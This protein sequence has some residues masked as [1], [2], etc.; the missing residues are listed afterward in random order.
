MLILRNT[1]PQF[2]FSLQNEMGEEKKKRG[3]GEAQDP[4]SLK[5]KDLVSS[6][7]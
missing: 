4:G 3:G 6:L 7:L 2:L 5:V 1:G